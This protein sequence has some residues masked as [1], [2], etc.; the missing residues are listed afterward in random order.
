[1]RPRRVI[2]NEECQRFNSLRT[3]YSGKTLPYKMVVRL[4][5]EEF[6]WK[7]YTLAYTLVN[8]IFIKVSRGEYAFPKEPIYIGKIQGVFDSLAKARKE[9]H[10][11]KKEEIIEDAEEIYS[12]HIKSAIR[13]LKDNGF[14]IAKRTFD[15]E[16]ALNSP[17]KPVSEFITIEE[18]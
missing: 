12:E 14:Y 6:G 4:L 15:F 10:E 17:S 8:K 16:A 1:M 7:S 13:L 18:F 5:R 9:K 3:L 2:T 11:A